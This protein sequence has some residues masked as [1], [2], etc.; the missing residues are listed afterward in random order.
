MGY[1]LVGDGST[2]SKLG[3]DYCTGVY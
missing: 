2:Y 1:S 3:P